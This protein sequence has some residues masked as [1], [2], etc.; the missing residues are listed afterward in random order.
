MFTIKKS[1]QIE[2]KNSFYL[3]GKILVNMVDM[4]VAYPN[5]LGNKRLGCCC[6]VDMTVPLCLFDHY[7]LLI[8]IY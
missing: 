4:T 6:M 2:L 8:Y 5:L 3:W 1:A 7:F